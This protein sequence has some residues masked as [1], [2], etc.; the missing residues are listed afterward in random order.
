[1]HM[2]SVCPS[3]SLSAVFEYI[4][5]YVT[6][7]C[8]FIPYIFCIYLHATS[9]FIYI[10]IKQIYKL[11]IHKQIHIYIYIHKALCG[12]LPP[13]PSAGAPAPDT[14]DVDLAIVHY[15]RDAQVWHTQLD[16]H[17]HVAQMICSISRSCP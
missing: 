14:L 4:Y 3:L 10:Y 13:G 9:F 11:Y 8:I 6:H 1:M 12:R 17:D 15:S 16:E 7:L 2:C 5:I